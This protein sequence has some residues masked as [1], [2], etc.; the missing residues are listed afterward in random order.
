MFWSGAVMSIPCAKE[1]P[2]RVICNP[3]SGGG[4]WNPQRLRAELENREFDWLLTGD[5]GEAREA[6]REW[7]SGLLVVAGGMVR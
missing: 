7:R 2:T 1:A 5:P 3:A 4:A 6:A